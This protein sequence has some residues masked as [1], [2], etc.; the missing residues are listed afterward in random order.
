[1]PTC[2]DLVVLIVDVLV[3]LFLP[4]CAHDL[5]LVPIRIAQRWVALSVQRV[6]AAQRLHIGWPFRSGSLFF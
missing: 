6:F 2:L 4:H 1:M 5:V 3:C